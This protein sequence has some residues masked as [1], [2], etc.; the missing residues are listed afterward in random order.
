MQETSKRLEAG[1]ATAQSAAAKGGAD[2]KLFTVGC[3]RTGP[4]LPSID[5]VATM[6]CI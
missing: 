6:E 1:A 4:M 2:L 5:G 3:L